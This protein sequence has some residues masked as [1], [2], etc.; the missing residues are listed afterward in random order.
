MNHFQ[1]PVSG[2][3]KPRQQAR[4]TTTNLIQ[5]RKTNCEPSAN[6]SFTQEQNKQVEPSPFESVR[7]VLKSPGRLI[8]LPVRSRFEGYFGTDFS[9]VRIH[10]GSEAAASANSIFASAYTVGNH[11]AFGANNYQPSSIQGQQLLAHELTHVVQQGNSPASLKTLELGQP[12]SRAEY[13]AR[14][15][16]SNL[17]VSEGMQSS[18]RARSPHCIQRQTL[19]PNSQ[20]DSQSGMSKENPQCEFKPSW[21]DKAVLWLTEYAD[22]VGEL[23]LG[24]IPVVGDIYDVVT[25]ILGRTPVSYTHL[26]LPT[27]A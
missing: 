9:Q 10:T 7:R 1:I 4:S 3:K 14:E 13:E 6:G 27:K 18:I 26:T 22:D 21:L 8:D 23:G 24:L 16:E 11:I 17:A 25:A 12:D 19:E 20:V 2:A 5:R 15:I